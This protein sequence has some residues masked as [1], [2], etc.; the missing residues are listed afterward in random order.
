MNV[1]EGVMGGETSFQICY[2]GD[3]TVEVC[4]ALRRLRAEPN[5]DQSWI[6]TA[7]DRS[8]PTIARYL[9]MLIGANGRML[10]ARTHTGRQRD[11][12]LV[13]H[14]LTAGADYSDLHDAIERLGTACELPFESTFVLRPHREVEIRAI[15][16]A[17]TELCP[18]DSLMVTGVSADA[19]WC[20]SDVFGETSSGAIELLG[21]RATIS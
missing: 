12:L 10:V 18:D 6:V 9:R 2:E 1:E 7:D 5:F 21:R 4:A 8:A 17:L 11:F 13:R 3:L 15:G 19:A 20:V 14:S 16:E